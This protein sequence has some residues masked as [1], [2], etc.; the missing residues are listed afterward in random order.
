MEVDSTGMHSGHLLAGFLS[1][2]VFGSSGI[3]KMYYLFVLYF[4]INRIIY[5]IKIML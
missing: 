2:K 1:L 4:L 3:S 5:V